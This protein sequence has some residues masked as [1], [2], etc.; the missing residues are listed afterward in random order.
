M[1]N[2]SGDRLADSQNILNRWKDLFF[3]LLNVHNMSEFRQIAIH[4][5]EPLVDAHSL[6]GLKL[7]L[8]S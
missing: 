8:Q 6:Q 7:V 3:Q 5:P 2:D 1:K 4:T